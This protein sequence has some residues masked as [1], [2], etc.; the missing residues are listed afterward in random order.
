MGGCNGYRRANASWANPDPA[1]TVYNSNYK[2]Q[3]FA[4]WVPIATIEFAILDM[5]GK[6]AKSS[7]IGLLI[8]DKIHNAAI[9]CLPGQRRA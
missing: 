7:S 9:C 8:S 6:I 3:D 5:F 2:A 4:I 1:A